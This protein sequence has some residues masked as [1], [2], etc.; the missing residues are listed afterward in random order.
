MEIIRKLYSLKPCQRLNGEQTCRAHTEMNMQQTLFV[1]QYALFCP[2]SPLK[3]KHGMP[4]LVVIV[5]FVALLHRV[6][7]AHLA[8][9][10]EGSPEPE[11]PFAIDDITLSQAFYARLDA[12][13]ADYYR[14]EA[15][16]G[17]PLYLTMLV[18][19][20]RYEAGF[21]PTV[22]LRGPGLPPDGLVLPSSDQGKRFGTTAYQRTQRLSLTAAGG[23]YLLE[24]RG[25]DA[26]VYCFC[27]GNR[28]PDSYADAATRAR[29]LT[30]LES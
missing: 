21:H 27:C 25:N 11:H 7:L 3:E 6:L 20:R 17:T 28:E 14:F 2:W 16:P 30:L 1:I 23:A 4:F 9:V 18:P 10:N 22:T 15:A 29:V 26:G 12:G 13:S 5:S 8:V 24:V 19:L